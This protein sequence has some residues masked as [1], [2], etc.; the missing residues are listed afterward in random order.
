MWPLGSGQAT[1]GHFLYCIICRTPKMEQEKAVTSA[2]VSALVVDAECK[3]VVKLKQFTKPP[4]KKNVYFRALPELAFHFH[5]LASQDA[6]EVMS[7]TD[8]LAR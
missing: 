8:S 1:T 7:V 4:T 5:F 2:L 3:K 6:I